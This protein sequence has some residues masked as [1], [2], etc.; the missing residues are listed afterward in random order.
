V[1]ESLPRSAS[2]RKRLGWGQG[3]ARLSST[4][5]S[6]A[7]T[8][9]SLLSSDLKKEGTA[10]DRADLSMGKSSVSSREAHAD[11]SAQHFSRAELHQEATTPMS[12]DLDISNQAESIKVKLEQQFDAQ[13]RAQIDRAQIDAQKIQAEI[14]EKQDQQKKI[15][16]ELDDVDLNI[17]NL[18]TELNET[19]RE[20]SKLEAEESQIEKQIK[21]KS[22]VISSL[23]TKLRKHLDKQQEQAKKEKLKQAKPKKVVI[24]REQPFVG[25]PYDRKELVT[26]FCEEN[27][28]RALQSDI[29]LMKCMPQDLKIKCYNSKQYQLSDEE[30]E[31]YS[32]EEEAMEIENGALTTAYNELDHHRNDIHFDEGIQEMMERNKKAHAKCAEA[33]TNH[34]TRKRKALLEAHFDLGLEYLKHR[35]KWLQELRLKKMNKA[36]LANGD[37]GS[38]DGKSAHGAALS[39]TSALESR[40]SH[41]DSPR[42]RGNNKV[43]AGFVRSEYEEMRII[44]RLQAAEKMKTLTR[45]PNMILLDSEERRWRRFDTKN[46]LITS[47]EAENEME[48]E[49]I[50]NIWT[51]RERRIFLE[52]YQQFPKDFT[53]IASFLEHRSTADCLVFYYKN[54]KSEEF[55]AI[56][57]KHQ[58]KKRRL[59]TEAKKMAITMDNRE[60]AKEKGREKEKGLISKEEKF[61]KDKEKSKSKAKAKVKVKGGNSKQQG[62]QGATG[63]GGK[64]QGQQ[65]TGKANKQQGQQG[66]GSKTAKQPQVQQRQQGQQQ[67]QQQQPLQPGAATAT[68]N[69]AVLQQHMQLFLANP[70]I[71]AA[72][73]QQ[74]QIQPQ[75]SDPNQTTQNQMAQSVQ[76]A[77]QQQLFALGLQQMQMGLMGY[78]QQQQQM[79]QPP[80]QVA[81][82][83][84]SHVEVQKRQI[85]YWTQEEKD[86]FM[87]TFRQHGRDWKLLSER[88]P[89]KTVNQIK[90]F[91]QNYKQKLGL[92]QIELPEG[93]IGPRKR[94]KKQPQ[95]KPPQT[96]AGSAVPKTEPAQGSEAEAPGIPEKVEAATENLP[97]AEKAPE[98]PEKETATPMVTDNNEAK[99]TTPSTTSTDV[100]VTVN[101]GEGEHKGT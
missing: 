23:E 28:A 49:K 43:L 34:L 19:R 64:Q 96:P 48:E 11:G 56:R 17:S 92:D 93:A 33:I 95:G 79:Q 61:S 52:K 69:L 4:P 76:M 84:G 44:H 58:M 74:Q 57:R 7:K 81:A 65:S 42:D 27:K 90:T 83:G 30:E 13:Q 60:K 67:G 29:K 72:M 91:Y 68:E 2:G 40:V 73:Q 6:I 86:T 31:E 25:M 82:A 46:G 80:A 21:V 41:R 98:A 62:Q 16:S 10:H 77:F 70:M 75:A 37:H 5:S 71:M 51:P 54:Q 8:P 101:Q 97:P 9:A 22:R 78:Q 94:N 1:G 55:A 87:S 88:I 15:L 100:K 35:E 89:G 24:K 14:K 45:V 59:Y 39:R 99:P 63:K 53:K 26:S 20:C 50:R 66:A 3:L 32:E 85:S 36:H 38:R 12:M 47:E 18:E